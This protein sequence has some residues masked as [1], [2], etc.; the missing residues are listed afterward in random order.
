VNT[1]IQI[2]VIGPPQR[3]VLIEMYDH[4]EPLGA[5]FGLPPRTSEARH[6][7]IGNALGQFVTL[8]AFSP[9]GEVVGHCFLAADKPNSAEIAVFVRQEFR[10]KGIGV[11]LVKKALKWAS[12]KGLAYVW[13]VTAADNRAA[14]QLLTSSGFRLLKFTFG[15]V[16]LDIDLGAMARVTVR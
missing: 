14:L 12:A 8:A 13:A 15:T 7:W 11:E 2:R 10:R 3:D 5:A 4:F 16:K 9:A 1:N 6:Q